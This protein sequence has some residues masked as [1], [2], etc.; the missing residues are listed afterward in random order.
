MTSTAA[1]GDTGPYKG[2]TFFTEDDAAYFFGRERDRDLIVANLKARRLGLLYGPSGV[3]KSSL[4]RAG[5]AAV[6]R[7]V[8]RGDRDTF[9]SAEFIPV[10]C[11]TWQDDPAEAVRT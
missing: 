2:L 11:S 5:V 9:G 1:T 8:A 6:L 7:S 4:L 10:V 3:G